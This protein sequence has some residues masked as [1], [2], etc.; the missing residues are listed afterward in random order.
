MDI[1][2][3]TKLPLEASSN[4][5]T[6][7]GTNLIYGTTQG[8]LYSLDINTKKSTFLIDLNERISGLFYD[9]ET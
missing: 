4:A 3:Y 1:E 5:I 2:L 7:N 6:N 9:K 8:Q